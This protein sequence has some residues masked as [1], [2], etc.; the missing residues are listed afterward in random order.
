MMSTSNTQSWPEL[1]RRAQALARRRMEI[2]ARRKAEA[3]RKQ[4][5]L[6]QAL[7]AQARIDAA[8]SVQEILEEVQRQAHEHAVGAYEQ[9]LTALL[10]DVLPG[11]R[12]VVLDLHAERGVS[13]MDVFI[14]KGDDQP[15]EDAWLGTGGSVTNLLSTGL[16]LVALMRS[17][18][19]RFMVLDESDCWIKPEL[20]DR[21]AGVVAQMAQELGVQIL[22]ISHHDESLFAKHVNY[23]LRMTKLDSQ[24]QVE[25]SPDS[26][27]PTWDPQEEGLRSIGLFDFQS[28]QNTIV[29]LAPGVTLLQGDNDIGKSA[30]VN[31]LR[32]V[33][34]GNSNDTMIRHFAP[35]A[36]VE[37]D[38]G[39]QLLTWI[40]NR[41][42]KVKVSYELTDSATGQTIHATNGTQPPD[43]LT[44]IIGIG[45]VDDLDIQIGQQQDPVFLLN[46]PASKRAKALAV[47]QESGHIQAMMAL[48]KQEL[49]AAKST[50]KQSEQE[51]EQLR[52][53]ELAS[54]AIESTPGPDPETLNQARA[55]Q[56]MFNQAQVL[57]SKW[58]HAL[59]VVNAGQLPKVKPVLPRLHGEQGKQ[60]LDYWTELENLVLIVGDIRRGKALASIPQPK[61]PELV[62]LGQ[63][64]AQLLAVV[65]PCAILKG[66]PTLPQTAPLPKAGA[67][68][69]LSNTWNRAKLRGQ[70]LDSLRQFRLPAAPDVR[71]N[72]SQ[73]VLAKWKPVLDRQAA[74]ALV[75]QSQTNIEVP[76]ARSHELQARLEQWNN[77]FGRMDASRKEIETLQQQEHET[78]RELT[79]KF[80]V[81]PTCGQDIAHYHG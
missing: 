5:L 8:P 39:S 25:W 37:I 71:P 81:C 38:M 9:M 52:L 43:W 16:R 50:L 1:E 35:K 28:H 80:P 27:V 19:R 15:L 59:V 7:A 33:F 70:I 17:G 58:N 53:M 67:M 65:K 60:L 36:R 64:W 73:Q 10:A 51:I 11:E 76:Q 78:R 2:E 21:Y 30:V 63:R 29:P 69:S 18:R 74:L 6:S 20:I 24:I 34:D 55:R 40:R 31:A 68:V 79:E 12:E 42:G 13:G 57:L 26:D 66:R 22:M 75:R 45:R 62:G 23:R 47:G 3:N 54:R 32:A 44:A 49:Q 61:A 72:M 56:D 41:K 4:T 46:Q 14:R 77:V 48:D